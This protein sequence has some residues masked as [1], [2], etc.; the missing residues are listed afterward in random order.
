MANVTVSS[1][2]LDALESA[3]ARSKT[4][5]IRLRDKADAAVREIVSTVEMST[6]AF[7]MGVIEENYKTSSNK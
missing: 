6:A 5:A 3:V 7:G 1:D 4:Q 2:E